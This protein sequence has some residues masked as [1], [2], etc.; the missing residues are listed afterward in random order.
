MKIKGEMGNIQERNLRISPSI[1]TDTN[2]MAWTQIL[3]FQTSCPC[4]PLSIH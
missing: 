4:Q 3:G 1:K 2:N